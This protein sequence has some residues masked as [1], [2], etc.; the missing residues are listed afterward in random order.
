[1]LPGALIFAAMVGLSAF[2]VR[3]SGLP[4]VPPAALP[5]PSLPAPTDSDLHVAPSGDDRAAGT[6]AAP[7][8]T[9][10]QAVERA[11]PGST[12]WLEPG[13][14]PEF[15]IG[16]GAPRPLRIAAATKGTAMIDGGSSGAAVALRGAHDVELLNLVVNGPAGGTGSAILIERSDGVTVA[17]ST[18]QGT[19]GGFGVEARF[20]ADLTI[21]GNDIGHNAV[22]IR[23]FGEGD[24][25]S[26]HDVAIEGNWIHDSDSMIVNDPAP[27]ND[28]GGN[29]IIWHHV[30]GPT[31]ARDNQ[32]WGNRATSHDYGRDGGA[33]E[34]WAS[35][36]MEIDRNRI[37][38][39]VNVLETGSDGP[40][41]VN[42]TY[43]RNVAYAIRDGVG[44]ILRC[45]RDSLF[46][47]NLFDGLGGYAFELSDRNGDNQFAESLDGLRI[48]DNIVVGSPAYV[49]RNDLEG[50]ITADHNLV[51][52][53]VGPVA[54]LPNRG[55]AWSVASLNSA[56]GFDEHSIEAQPLFVDELARD[57]R[58][59]V[60]SMAIDRGS[61]TLDG[62][63][64]LGLAPDI[65]PYEGGVAEPPS[66]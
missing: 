37:W 55:T 52:H 42:I 54:R 51:W 39:N 29:A 48:L 38:D 66:S 13:T 63:E 23:L 43:T 4:S 59:R 31:S 6:A 5:E 53:P 14:Y 9:V 44:A 21:R 36:N 26:V 10:G 62:Q 41:C 11:E 32:M 19:T 2:L 20:S 50:S 40:D 47:H 35:S 16:S 3:G 45:A 18:I 25:A 58:P 65:G 28:F 27:D 46:T 24:P 1:M 12:I 30:T 57:Y 17:G 33:F 7:L 34:I 56:T 22:G 60:G 64:V 15:A 61:I 49:I 8:A